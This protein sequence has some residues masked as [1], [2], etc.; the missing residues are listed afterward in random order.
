MEN[1]AR[2]RLFEAKKIHRI[3]SDKLAQETANLQRLTTETEEK[4]KEGIEI[5]AL[6]R[7]EDKIK[8]LAENIASIKKNLEEK[9]KVVD[10]EQANLLLRS[11]EKKVMERLKEEQNRNWR[12]YLN[13]KEAAML[14]EIAVLRHGPGE[15]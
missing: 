15:I 2:N 14:D 10:V 6:I 1:I 11:K 7:F 4:K 3:I 12:N 9:A 8:A 5:G 13:K